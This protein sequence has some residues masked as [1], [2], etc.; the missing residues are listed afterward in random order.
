[1]KHTLQIQLRATEGA[2]LR[3]LGMVERRGFRLEQVQVGEA[4]GD[5]HAV[6]IMVSGDRPVALLKRQLERIYDIIWV[7][8]ETETTGSKAPNWNRGAGV[9]PVSRRS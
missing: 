7:E 8:I 6:H 5:G 2:I 1:M 9:R 4:Q 3:A